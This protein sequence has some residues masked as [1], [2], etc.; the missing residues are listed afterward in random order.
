MPPMTLLVADEGAGTAMR[1]FNFFSHVLQILEK[2]PTSCKS[3]AD[4]GEKS[5]SAAPSYTYSCLLP[6]ACDV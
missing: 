4:I 3:M 5:V 6:L 1:S 2:F